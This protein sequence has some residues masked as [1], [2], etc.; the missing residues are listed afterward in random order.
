MNKKSWTN[1]TVLVVIALV[2]LGGFLFN[3]ARQSSI[4][5]ESRIGVPGPEQKSYKRK[6]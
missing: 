4:P 3:K 5:E 1:M 2:L 6:T